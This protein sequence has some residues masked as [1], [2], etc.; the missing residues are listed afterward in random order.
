MMVDTLVETFLH[1]M[2]PTEP[3]ESTMPKSPEKGAR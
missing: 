1:G 3:H 2:V